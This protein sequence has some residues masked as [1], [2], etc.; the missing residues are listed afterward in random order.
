MICSR[1]VRGAFNAFVKHRRQYK[2]Q[3][4]VAFKEL[5]ATLV[6]GHV[7]L[8]M[9]FQERLS[10][11][12]QDV[13][14]SPSAGTTKRRTSSPVPI[15]LRLRGRVWAYSSQFLSKDM[16]QDNAWVRHVVS[17]LWTDHIPALLRK[18][19][20]DPMTRATMFTDNCAKQFKGRFHFE[21]VAD[22]GIMVR[23][24]DGK[25]TGERRMVEHHYFGACHWKNISD[26]E[27]GITKTYA[28]DQV[29]NQAW[30]VNSSRDLCEKQANGLKFIYSDPTEEKPVS[31]YDSIPQDRG[32]RQILVT[33]V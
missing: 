18:I 4:Q 17:M 31:F 21:W 20:A 16:T 10:I 15:F 27:G 12:E 25:P 32:S 7:V 1:E 3:E 6:Y 9:Y 14:F 2:T 13:S 19:G 8:V 22:S 33:K 23:D 5:K 28:R 11:H 26:S 24:N 30:K 29:T